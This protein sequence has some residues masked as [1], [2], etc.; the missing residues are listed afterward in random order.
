MSHD[1]LILGAS[2]FIGQRLAQ[3]LGASRA[4]ATYHAHPAP[5]GV[6]FDALSDS[7]AT[8]GAPLTTARHAF[9]LFGITHI[10]VCAREP[11]RAAALNITATR[12]VIEQLVA[13]GIVPVFASTDVVFDGARGG[14]REEDAPR[15]ILTYGRQKLEIEEFI[16]EHAP[17]HLILRLPKLIGD[18]PGDGG[19]LDDWLRAIDAGTPIVCAT[20]QVFSPIALDDAVTAMIALIESGATGTYHLGGPTA[21][22]RADLFDAFAA[23]LRKH[24]DVAARMR[25]CSIRDFPQFAEARPLDITMNSEKLYRATGFVPRDMTAVCAEFAASAATRRK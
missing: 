24:R 23:A 9:I 19:M 3:R 1:T 12:S 11:A 15:P 7:L 6:T 16:R 8:L 10:D 18:R 5:G 25:R 14:Y 2:G 17:R 13:R 21:W 22:N 4:L 20:D